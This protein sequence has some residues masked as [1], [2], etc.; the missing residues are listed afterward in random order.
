MVENVAHVVA[1]ELITAAQACNFHAPLRSSPRL[2]R[3]RE[4]LRARVPRLVEDRY[5]APDIAAAKELV[6]SGAIV[7][8]A[9][10]DDLPTLEGTPG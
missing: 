3:V 4:V 8:A 5:L 9:G 1:I 7:S 10:L 6:S 2:E